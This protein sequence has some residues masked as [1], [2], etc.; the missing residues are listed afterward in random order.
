MSD[1]HELVFLGTGG[2]CGNPTFY[3]GCPACEE[4]RENPLEAKTCS[5]V[6]MLGD[7]ITLI[8]TAPE[9]RLQL[10]RERISHVDRVLFT[11]EHFDHTGGFAQLEYPIR[12]G[13]AKSLPV[14][15]TARCLAWLETHFEWMWDKVDAH[16][17]EPFDRFEFDG[18]A[19]TAFP[20]AHCPDAIGY[21]IEAHE[22]RIAYVP[23]TGPL[24]AEVLTMLH[25]V[26]T[27]IHDS[28]FVGSNWMP[29]THTN[30]EGTIQLGRD[31]GAK[32]VYCTHC[33][34][35]FDTPRTAADLREEFERIS[36][37]GMQAVLP[38]DGM[39][40]RIA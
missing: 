20:A 31:L 29:E 18:V 27:L 8:D 9:L 3:C 34:M 30:I 36:A 35:H 13:R 37:D 4:A 32:A 23:D 28:T 12:L 21:L 26:D 11:H 33:T 16:V 19:Y 10:T 6:A 15:A 2:A 5:S 25:G 40:I 17:V 7:E 14:Y 38:R 24:S 22:K 1:A 39:R